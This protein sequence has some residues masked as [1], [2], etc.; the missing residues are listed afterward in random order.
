V[1]AGLL[2]K[3][4]YRFQGVSPG[5]DSKQLLCLELDLPRQNQYQ[6]TEQRRRFSEQVVQQLSSLP[7]VTYVGVTN[8]RPLSHE[9]SFQGFRIEAD[10]QQPNG[11]RQEAE[12]RQ[13]NPT[14]FSAMKIPLKQGRFFNDN[15]NGG[16]PVMIINEVFAQRF[17]PNKNP[18]DKIINFRGRQCRVVGVVG[19]VKTHGMGL[20]LVEY[21]PMMYEPQT[22]DCNYGMAFMIKT[23][24]PPL[25]LAQ[26]A[27]EQIWQ[28]DPDQPIRDL[29][30]MESIAG[31][32]VAIQ[33]VATLSTIII[34][35][36]AL[37]LSVT[38][39]YGLMSYITNQRIREYGIRMALGAQPVNIHWLA[40]KRG[41]ILTGS[42][43][44]TGLVVYLALAKSLSGM[45]YKVSAVD[46]LIILGIPLL[47]GLAALLGSHI[48]ARRAA[49]IDPMEALRYE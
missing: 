9:K 41:L 16:Q 6:T 17:F 2:A 26:A 27:S 1:G 36:G 39:I 34:S 43:L 13:I 8:M 33:Y 23:K 15:D 38:G 35:A 31:E 49:K 40:I 12:Y 46:P 18:L 47:L 5:F 45:L 22:Q 4:F 44:G 11:P 3:S 24:V 37:I 32:S 20:N 42:G 25:S 7:G 30:T 14:F 48:P 29:Q 19:N 21:P 28:V 10:S